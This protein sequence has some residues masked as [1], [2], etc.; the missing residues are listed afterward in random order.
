[1]EAPRVHTEIVVNLWV[2]HDGK[3]AL[4]GTAPISAVFDQT[5]Q[6]DDLF[7]TEYAEADDYY[8]D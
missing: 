1:M 5:E 2:E 4:I 7:G 3:M 6:F 8:N